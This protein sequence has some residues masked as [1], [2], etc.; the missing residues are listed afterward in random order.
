MS[1]AITHRHIDKLASHAKRG[2]SLVDK[3][4]ETISCIVE[5]AG[6]QAEGMAAGALAALCDHY[7]GGGQV[8]TVAGLPV[9]G[10]AGL[11]AGAVS[12]ALGSHKAAGH[13]AAVAAT[14]EGI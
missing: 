3:H 6:Y 2:W 5:H 12:L 4:K 7:L 8:A 11:G 1:F 9:V 14:W 13:L 10:L